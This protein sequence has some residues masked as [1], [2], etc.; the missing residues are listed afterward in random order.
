MAK[1]RVEQMI[2]VLLLN[3]TLKDVLKETRLLSEDI[4]RP[5][6]SNKGSNIQHN[7]SRIRGL[8]SISYTPRSGLVH[9]TSAAH[10]QN[11][12]WINRFA[13]DP[14]DRLADR[15]HAP[16]QPTA[17]NKVARGDLDSPSFE[18]IKRSAIEKDI[19]TNRGNS[20][21]C[22]VLLSLRAL[23]RQRSR[24]L[25]TIDWGKALGQ[26]RSSVQNGNDFETARACARRSHAIRPER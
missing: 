13:L 10:D 14:I 22:A 15:E 4:S 17:T 1:V 11:R 19:D 7:L 25:P 8:T 6:K 21:T 20:T 12:L 18:T 2:G 5:A 26:P 16:T 24:T 9:Y 3:K 23:Y